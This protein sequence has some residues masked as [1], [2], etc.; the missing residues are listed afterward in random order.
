MLTEQQY[1]DMYNRS[2]KDPK[3]FWSEQA[4]KCLTWFKRW[5]DVLS[6]DFTKQNIQWF[7]GGKLNACYNCVDRH[8]EQ[9]AKQTAIIFQGDEP[10][11]VRNITYSELHESVCRLANVLKKYRVKKGDRVCIYMPMIPEAII[12]M[13]A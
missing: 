13:L 12:A 4:E 3:H 11:D 7:K 6:G 5:D 10:N 2:L 8:L 1:Q 9:R